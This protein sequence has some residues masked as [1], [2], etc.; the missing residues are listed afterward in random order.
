MIYFIPR[1][2]SLQVEN[3]KLRLREY[4]VLF[5]INASICHFYFESHIVWNIDDN[6]FLNLLHNYSLKFQNL[7]FILPIYPSY[8]LSTILFA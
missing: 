6:I 8:I 4:D 2:K 5:F 7:I 1:I 3:I